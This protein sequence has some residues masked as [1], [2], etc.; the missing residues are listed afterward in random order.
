VSNYLVKEAY[1]LVIYAA[2]TPEP[3]SFATPTFVSVT[4]YVLKEESLL[5]VRSVLPALKLSYVP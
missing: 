1:K 2:L 4:A 3:T 5:L